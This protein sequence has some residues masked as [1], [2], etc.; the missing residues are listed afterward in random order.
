[1][2]KL[3][4]RFLKYVSFDTTSDINSN[5]IPSTKKQLKLS[6]FLLSELKKMNIDSFLDDK[7]YLYAKLDSNK[8]GIPSL[9]LL[10]HVDTSCDAPGNNIKPRIIKKYDGKEIKLNDS[11]TMHP[12]DFPDLLSVLDHDLIVTDG[13]TLLGADDKLGIAIIMEILNYL[14]DNPSF[15]HGD[16]YVCFT[17]DEEIGRGVNYFNY[18]YFKTDYTYTLDGSRAGEVSYE[19]FNAASAELKFI[20]KSIHPGSAKNKMINSTHLLMEFH[21][22]LDKSLDPALTEKYEGFNHLANMKGSVELSTAYYIIRN[23]NKDLF[24]KQKN[25][26][27]N[28]TNYLNN[29]YNYEAVILDIKDSYYNMFDIL[30][31]KKNIINLPIKAINNLGYKLFIDPIRGGTDGAHLTFNGLPCPNLGTGG[32]QFH[33]RYEFASINEAMM[34]FNIVIEMIKILS[35][36]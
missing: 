10:A 33:G 19:N 21:S 25:D 18:E 26:F 35:N 24:N 15:E 23:H 4:K 28:I 6:K 31:D 12:K 27:I 34:S 29:K 20:G 9:G 7:G 36:N 3:V 32:Y 13:N 11:L 5:T 8:E 17:P 1:M 16:I 14:I 2:K 30:K 22:M